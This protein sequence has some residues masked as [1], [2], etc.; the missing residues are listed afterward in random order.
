M[1]KLKDVYKTYY[2]GEEKV[3]AVQN[4]S[5]EIKEK[6]FVSILGPS[7]CGKSTLMYLIGLLETPTSGRILIDE[8]NVSHLEDDEQSRLRNE[9]VG[10][11]FQQFNLINK[12]TVLENIL[13]PTRY[14]K[15]KLKF[16]PRKKVI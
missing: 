3:R 9:Y 2:L 5:L 7:G 6:E 14:S 1:I 10:F 13:L 4:V 12:F 11:V 15:I 16:S 8:K